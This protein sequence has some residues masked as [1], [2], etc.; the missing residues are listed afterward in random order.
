MASYRRAAR[1]EWSVEESAIFAARR[2]F[3]LLKLLA[4]EP[5]KKVLATARRLKA[6]IQVAT[7][8]AADT[9]TRRECEACDPAFL[10][11]AGTGWGSDRRG[12]CECAEATQRG[13]LGAPPCG[14]AFCTLP[15]LYA[16]LAVRPASAPGGPT[17][18][19]GACVAYSG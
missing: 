14:K 6:F 16:G 15:Q 13:A 10:R 3:E 8:A 12:S 7:A 17:A 19:H 9:R 2:D 1:R 4:A 18:A 11:R 5:D